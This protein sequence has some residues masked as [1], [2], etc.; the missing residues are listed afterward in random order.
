MPKQISNEL[1]LKVVSLYYLGNNRDEIAKLTG[2]GQGTVSNILHEFENE[3]GK[4]EFEAIKIHGKLLRKNNI[5]PQESLKGLRFHRMLKDH[6]LEEDLD[7]FLASCF[8]CLDYDGDLPSLVTATVRLIHLEDSLGMHVEKI[9]H[10]YQEMAS[11][12]P[13]LKDQIT[14]L[15]NQKTE[16]QTNLTNT[17]DK[18][19]VTLFGLD[20]F[21]RTKQS[22]VRLGIPIDDLVQYENVLSEITRLGFDPKRIIEKIEQVSNLEEYIKTLQITKNNLD[23]VIL[24]DKNEHV[25]LASTFEKS[26]QMLS[27]Q[28]NFLE[29]E[30]E[31]LTKKKGQLELSLKEV[32]TKIIQ[33]LASAHEQIKK[34]ENT[35]PLRMIYDK[36][37]KPYLVIPT[38]IIFLDELKT[39][40][41][42]NIESNFTINRRIDDVIS[43]LQKAL[44]KLAI[45]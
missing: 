8:E 45:E 25:K 27:K 3:I 7:Q 26:I 38:L 16:S 32:E 43:E 6:V 40:L 41:K 44:K 10:H 18:N 9:L 15:K 28:R 20:Q 17:L 29:I 34:L 12:I 2:L 4:Q 24:S 21:A 11:Q 33:K 30:I 13:I 5:S 39:W 22:L 1:K 37:G 36:N 19:K 42:Q 14:N 23:Q 35:D 31:S